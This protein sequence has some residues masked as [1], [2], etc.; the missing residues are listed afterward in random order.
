M[1][2]LG[3]R[4]HP[5]FA[6]PFHRGEKAVQTRAGVRMIAERSGRFIRSELP[7]E[8][9]EF[10][11]EL[12]YVIVGTVDAAGNPFAS[13]LVGVPG[14]VSSLDDHTLVIEAS[15]IPGDPIASGLTVGASIG[16]LGIELE[17]RRRN[18]ANGVITSVSGDRIVVDVHE[19][20][21][22]C[23]QYIQTRAPL[24]AVRRA[25]RPPQIENAALSLRALEVLRAAD[26]LFIASAF[27]N[28]SGPGGVDVS[29][30][31]G[32]PGFVAASGEDATVLTMPDFSG[33]NFFMT[34][35]NLQENPRAG[36]VVVD[37]ATGAML[38]L[39]GTTEIVW[40]GAEVESFLGAQRLVKLRVSGG[41]LLEG[42][43]P[44]T[45]SAPGYAK[46]LARTGSW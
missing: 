22:N 17:T 4:R 26:T 8:D 3:L 46:Q 1:S 33:N 20:F 36:M 41:V 7:D 28:E 40:E 35:G 9:R 5:R 27:P 19:S 21:G 43:I 13:M 34:L 24:S 14:F 2:D 6:S 12:L 18:R 38:S 42:A 32:K 39:T 30:R 16:L 25:Q 31:G 11:A 37:F 45:W 10:F 15:I 44:F 23:P 29:H